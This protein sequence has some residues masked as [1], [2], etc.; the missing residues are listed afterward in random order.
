MTVP[1]VREQAFL[2]EADW[3]RIRPVLLGQKPEIGFSIAAAARELGMPV[4]AVEGFLRWAVQE[5]GG[6]DWLAD[7]RD[8]FRNRRRYILEAYE[9]RIHRLAMTGDRD[10]LYDEHGN[11]VRTHVRERMADVLK[12]HDRVARATFDDAGHD[13]RDFDERVDAAWERMQARRLR[14]EADT[15]GP[16]Q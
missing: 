10:T 6:A 1:A 8:V 4:S 12:A 11:L 3:H 7:V 15:D 13:E 16:L 9:D 5:I 2:S 14:R